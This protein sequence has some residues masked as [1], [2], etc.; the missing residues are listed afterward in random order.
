M[1]S[2]LSRELETFVL[3][4]VKSGRYHSADDVIAEA[5]ALLREQEHL[6][7]LRRERLLRE[8]AD[9]IFQADNRHLLDAEEMIRGMGERARRGDE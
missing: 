9:G 5:L 8:L 4:L 2:G 1:A 6:R 7:A 3:E